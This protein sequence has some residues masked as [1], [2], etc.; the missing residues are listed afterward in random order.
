MRRDAMETTTSRW[1]RSEDAGHGAGAM[2]L[3]AAIGHWSVR[4]A[5]GRRWV[6]ALVKGGVAVWSREF[7]TRREAMEFA[8]AD[9]AA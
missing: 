8:E 9:A 4:R 7:P 1:V 6:A 3:D 5:N 2:L